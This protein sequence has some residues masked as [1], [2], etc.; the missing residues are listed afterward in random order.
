MTN[1]VTID[2]WAEHARAIARAGSGVA[3]FKALLEASR[4]AAPRAAVFLVRQGEV[5]GWG[6]F[7]YTMP[8]ARAQRAYRA[9][10]DA[11]W[12]AR[13][14]G[15]AGAPVFRDASCEGP[16]FGQ[17]PTGEWV[18]CA[19]SIGGRPLALVVGER[20]P[21]EPPWQPEGL[22]L[23][24]CMAELRL[25]LDLARRRAAGVAQQ[26]TPPAT[27]QKTEQETES[28]ATAASAVPAVPAV[29]AS[30]PAPD[31]ERARRYAR[32]VATDIRLYN[33]EAVMAG[34]RNGDL[35]D[36]LSDHLNR[37]RETFVR[38]HADLGQTGLELLHEAYVQVLA[39]G[40]AALVPAKLL[41]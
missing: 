22:S 3:V 24:A 17:P 27:E 21:G 41:D 29:P 1:G 16:E 11:G 2:E 25:E 34:R 26:A 4:I 39:G 35:A 6:S 8:L 40:D 28:P 30:E 10:R 23:L 31:L 13:I 36:R 19:V 37:G 14:V 15:G 7:G 9:P 20:G 18:G 38:R 32:L 33:E 12:V 5:Q